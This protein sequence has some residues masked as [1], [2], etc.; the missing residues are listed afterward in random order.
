MSTALTGA[1]LGMSAFWIGHKY[2][3]KNAVDFTR[4]EPVAALVIRG[5]LFLIS[6]N[7]C[8]SLA[9]VVDCYFNLSRIPCSAPQR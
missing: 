4:K 9:Y 3:C 7:S 6:A 5:V 8:R 1:R 2:L